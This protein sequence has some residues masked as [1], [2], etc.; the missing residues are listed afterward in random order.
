MKIS[1]T[2]LRQIIKE[3]EATLHLNE[4]SWYESLPSLLK[5]EE[6]KE[7]GTGTPEEEWETAREIDREL[8]PQSY[9]TGK[10]GEPEDDILAYERPA[11][12]N[13]FTT[14]PAAVF[15]FIYDLVLDPV[16][17]G[18]VGASKAKVLWIKYFP[19][20]ALPKVGLSTLKSIIKRRFVRAAA[21]ETG[22]GILA[23]AAKGAWKFAAGGAAP[24][25]TAWMFAEALAM[26]FEYILPKYWLELPEQYRNQSEKAL[27]IH[28]RKDYLFRKNNPDVFDPK[29]PGTTTKDLKDI[30]AYLQNNLEDK[31]SWIKDKQG[32]VWL[33]G[34]SM[35]DETAYWMKINYT[36][37]MKRIQEAKK[38]AIDKTKATIAKV[39]EK[40]DKT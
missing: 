20:E 31:Y 35:S 5:P 24:L 12:I 40:Q 23:Q 36:D 9:W 7:W 16:V 37:I 4:A 11:E 33:G 8:K 6:E 19:G 17:W 22:L 15:K 30:V 38:E 29:Y 21:T 26:T 28:H 18:L 13:W 27:I 25:I 14:I 32:V 3:E 2:R 39:E 1:R 10:P 34:G